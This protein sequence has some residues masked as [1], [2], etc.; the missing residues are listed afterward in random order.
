MPHP[1]R[2]LGELTGAAEV[3]GGDAAPA[4][5][6]L[7]CVCSDRGGRGVLLRSMTLSLTGR[8]T[9]PADDRCAAAD[10]PAERAVW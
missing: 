9:A 6:R 7:A 4:G 8:D 5:A 1:G 2:C 10:V 3:P